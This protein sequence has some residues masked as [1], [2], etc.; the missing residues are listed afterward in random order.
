[1]AGFVRFYGRFAAAC[2]TLWLLA[3]IWSHAFKRAVATELWGQLAIVVVAAAYAV[4]K[5][6]GRQIR[7]KEAELKARGSADSPT[8]LS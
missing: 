4:F 5:E 7:R 1:M 2:G 6:A 8:E 3:V